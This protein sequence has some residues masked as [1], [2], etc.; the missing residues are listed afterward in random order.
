LVPKHIV[1]ESGGRVKLSTRNRGRGT[2]RSM[3]FK[4]ESIETSM[5]KQKTSKRRDS[6]VIIRRKKSTLKILHD[7][8]TIGKLISEYRRFG[9]M[10]GCYTFELS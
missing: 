4:N 3:W 5:K 2:E 10:Q 9:V 1:F 6:R 7:T 8:D